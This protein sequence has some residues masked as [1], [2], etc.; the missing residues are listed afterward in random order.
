[1][2]PTSLLVEPETRAMS[3]WVDSADAASAAFDTLRLLLEGSGGVK[4]AARVNAT[5]KTARDST[6]PAGWERLDPESGPV[7]AGVDWVS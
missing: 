7:E 6:R 4:R 2:D 5:L 1:L 3:R